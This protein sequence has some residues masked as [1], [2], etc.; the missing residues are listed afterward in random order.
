MAAGAFGTAF[1]A[2]AARRLGLGRL[3]NRQD[4]LDAIERLQD[5]RDRAGRDDQ[6][7]VANLAEHVLGG[8]RQRLEPR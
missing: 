2:V 3:K 6:L 1:D 8:M 7:A 5:Q 4:R